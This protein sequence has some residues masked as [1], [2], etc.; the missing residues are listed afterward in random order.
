MP[1]SSGNK[2]VTLEILKAVYDKLSSM[3][4]NHIDDKENPHEVDCEQIGAL[5]NTVTINGIEVEDGA[6]M[7]PVDNEISEESENPVQNKI[8]KA[9]IDEAVAD[10]SGVAECTVAD[11][12]KFLRVN[13]EG[14]AEWQEIGSAENEYF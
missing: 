11:K 1:A 8:I 12:G 6:F 9:Y 3:F 4:S 2:I 7:L 10:V 14:V 5:P 13:D